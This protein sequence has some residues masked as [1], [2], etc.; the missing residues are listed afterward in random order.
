MPYFLYIYF[1]A[2]YSRILYRL[3]F[4]GREVFPGDYEGL[5]PVEI[6]DAIEQSGL[7]I[8]VRF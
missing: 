5:Q 8:D 3:Q 4:D 1:R 7:N 6:R 2:I